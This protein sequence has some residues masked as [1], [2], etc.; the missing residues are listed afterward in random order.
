MPAPDI[1]EQSPFA[2]IGSALAETVEAAVPTLRA[3]SDARSRQPRAAGKWSPKQVIGHLIDSAANN[4]QRFVRAQV[5][6]DLVFPGY[7][8]DEWV[9]FQRYQEASWPHLLTLWRDYNLHIARVIEVMPPEQRLR[10]RRRHNLD[11]IAYQ[12]VPADRAVTL[13]Y[14]MRDYVGHLH[15]HLRQLRDLGVLTE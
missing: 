9:A 11:Q 1:S 8:Q 4:H 10:E 3:I 6:D 14:F 12:P 5:Q 2:A 13:D 7:A 15:H